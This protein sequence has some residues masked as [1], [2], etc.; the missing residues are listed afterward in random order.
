MRLFQFGPRGALLTE[1]GQFWATEA[2][3]VLRT[4]DEAQSRFV[5]AFHLRNGLYFA[6]SQVVAEYLVPRWL[7]GFQHAHTAPASVV[8]GNSDEVIDMVLSSR[9]DFAV[10][11]M[12]RPA[13]D[14]VV[15]A[16]L[17]MDRLVLVVPPGHALA[18]FGRP[19]T[20]AEVAATPLIHRESN[21]GSQL[22]W[23]EA[24]AMA[25]LE[26]A[27]PMLEVD[28]LAAV[29]MAVAGGVGPAIVPRIAVEDEI[30]G[31]RLREIPIDGLD[32]E[33]WVT[34]IWLP[35]AELSPLARSFVDHLRSARTSPLRA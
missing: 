29:K 34:A 9:V 5:T 10:L 26:V 24:F 12:G 18:R 15:S 21:S 27:P 33:V 35:A 7:A 8:V 4:L 14:E 23:K 20:V 28:S 22:K 6:A 30:A 3:K 32:L 11:E 31:R 17:F 19:L 2:L 1:A 13:P 16:Q 25:G